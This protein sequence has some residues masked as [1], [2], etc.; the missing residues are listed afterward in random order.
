MDRTH[1]PHP[2]VRALSTRLLGRLEACAAELRGEFPAYAFGV[3]QCSVGSDQ[4]LGHVFALEC[5]FPDVAASEPDLLSLCIE[6][7]GLATTPRINGN[8]CWGHPGWLE[9][10][11]WDVGPDAD[12]P[13]ASPAVVEEVIE[14][15]PRLERAFRD[16]VARAAPS[17]A[18]ESPAETE[19]GG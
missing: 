2:L 3:S 6:V 16:A 11:V 15:L 12:W 9:C 8:V 5:L 13:E 18:S 17:Y 4:Y 10:E 14:A 1:P 7:V 19:C